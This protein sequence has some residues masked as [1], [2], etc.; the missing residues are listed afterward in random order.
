M[1][2]HQRLWVVALLCLLPL[3]ASADME[4]GLQH[5]GKDKG[6][7]TLLKIISVLLILTISLWFFFGLDGLVGTAKLL[8]IF[9]FGI[10]LL[11]YFLQR[12][13][14]FPAPSYVSDPERTGG[15]VK[16]LAYAVP[17][18]GNVSTLYF[19][20]TGNVNSKILVFFHGN[21]DQLGWGAADLGRRFHKKGYQFMGVEYPGYGLAKS[22]TI[23]EANMCEAAERAMGYITGSH[24]E[25]G[26]GIDNRNIVLV[27]Q[28]LG[29]TVVTHLATK[30]WGGGVV[31]ISA[32]TSVADMSHLVLPS[33]LFPTT[34]VKFLV[35]DPM[36]N[37]A[38]AP[39]IAIPTKIIHGTRDSI[40]PF[41]MGQ[42]LAQTI[43]HADF[44]A[45][46]DA[47]HN[48]MFHPGFQVI[49]KMCDFVDGLGN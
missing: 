26:L 1:N 7:S 11:V 25:G 21:A 22:G 20:G 4:D 17:G 39:K 27:G 34:L 16:Q 12:S 31:L 23:S 42:K 13:M 10:L 3:A 49:Q 36:D 30:G 47:D 6:E 41:H 5:A 37:L 28:S 43:T 24:A 46:Q 38:R 19:S 29:S 45:V 9:Y 32:F 14:I 44:D 8:L 15:T 18:V 35:K 33:I 48:N 40:V 2:N